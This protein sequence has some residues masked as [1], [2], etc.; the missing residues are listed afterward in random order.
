MNQNKITGLILSAGLSERMGMLKPLIKIKNTP[1]LAHIIIKLSTVC[2]RIVIVTGYQSALIKNE[3]TDWLKDNN[4]NL[5]SSLTWCY[6]ADYKSG[7]LIS[8]QAGLKHAVDSDWVLYHFA[9]QPHIPQEF[10]KSFA[11]QIEAAI[12]W[13]QPSFN[14]QSAHPVLFSSRLIPQ[15]MKLQIHQSLRD[16]NNMGKL[17]QKK[18][19]CDFPEILNDIDTPQQLKKLL[20]SL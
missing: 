11:D 7:M 13:I 4:R 8:L 12:D 6:N 5:L 20:E 14:A 15:I 17:N 10:Y 1:F 18:W 2:Q 16:L 19:N 3:I 9:D